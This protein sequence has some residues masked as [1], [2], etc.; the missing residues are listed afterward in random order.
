MYGM[1]SCYSGLSYELR[2]HTLC[3]LLLVRRLYEL[4]ENR[5]VHI[6]HRSSVERK[7]ELP[8]V[9]SYVERPG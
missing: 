7:L 8:F 5:N 3:N 4:S 9:T 6:A 1:G 2:I